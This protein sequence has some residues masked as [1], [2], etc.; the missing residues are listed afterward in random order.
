MV[1]TAPSKED[2]Y[3]YCC[4]QGAEAGI[5][6]LLAGDHLDQWHKAAGVAI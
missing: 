3:E 2:L 1:P 4:A 5:D 6:T